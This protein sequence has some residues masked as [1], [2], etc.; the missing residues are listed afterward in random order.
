MKPS[1]I[2]RTIAAASIAL[3]AAVTS[4]Q[5]QEMKLA[6][7]LPPQH[8]YQEQVYG[9]FA[10]KIAA[11]TD[12]EVTVKVF[13]GGALGGNPIEQYNRA[14][15]GVAEIV[16]TLPGYTA[17]KFPMT[18]MTELPGV[19]TEEEATQ[20]LW[21][22][23][24]F[25]ADEHKRVHLLALWTNAE[26]VL[27]T[28][29]TPVRSLADVQGMKIR[30]PSRNAGLVVESWGA[31]PV[32]MPVPEIYNSLQTGVIDG[33]L[34]DGTA[35]YA[36]R[37]GEVANYVTSGMHASISPLALFMNRGAYR[38]LS[39]EHRAA[40]DEIGREISVI[41]NDVQLAG[42]ARGKQMFQ[43]LD[44]KEWIELTPEAAAEFNAASAG[45]V[46]QVVAAAEAEGLN[47]RAFV[48]ALGE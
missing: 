26:N 34:I 7:F 32:S 13:P 30:V 39:D 29:D 28:R 9:V 2:R 25:L 15:D 38:S 17:S 5:A 12:G 44:G 6:D 41:A 42:V 46:E 24:D 20:A 21:E 27:Y 43:D 18:L 4:A 48:E 10:D 37:L 23:I 8:A 36:F 1:H 11:A 14:N 19:V 22:N 3:S 16:F 47:A 31:V 40:F 35:T 45:V 33:V